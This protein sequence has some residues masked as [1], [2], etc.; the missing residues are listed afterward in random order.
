M[1]VEAIALDQP[2]F[3]A[4]ALLISKED[5]IR[6]DPDDDLPASVPPTSKPP[7]QSASAR[8]LALENEA[9][10]VEWSKSIIDE[11]KME[12][13][14]LDP[15]ENNFVPL[16]VACVQSR[17]SLPCCLLRFESD[18]LVFLG[19]GNFLSRN[20]R[21]FTLMTLCMKISPKS[22]V[23]I[24]FWCQAKRCSLPLSLRLLSFFIMPL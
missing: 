9:D 18:S 14:G 2:L 17:I 5:D 12:H 13:E 16:M 23:G 1:V 24:T 6:R 20:S 4:T 15:W 21:N 22:K 19:I 10:F 3:D 8:M 11:I 7:L